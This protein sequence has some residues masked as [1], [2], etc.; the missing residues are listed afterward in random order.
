[1]S[2]RRAQ[3]WTLPL[4]LIVALALVADVLAVSTSRGQDDLPPG[5][6]AFVRK[7]D[8][9]VWKNG[10]STRIIEDGNA[11][12]PRWSPS[13]RFVLFVRSGDSYSDLILYDLEQSTEQQVTF[14]QPDMQP[15]SPDYV[16]NTSWVIDPD[17]TPNGLIAFASDATSDN[18]V[19][20]WLLSSPDLAPEPAPAAQP[21]D[22]IEGVSLDAAGSIAAYTVRVRE[23]NGLSHSAVAIRNLSDGTTKELVDDPNGAFDPAVSP[24]GSKIA[25]AIRDNN[26]NS[27]IWLS[28][29]SG[30]LTRVTEGAQATQPSWSPDGT[31]LAYMR[32]VNYKFELWAV[33][34]QDTGFGEPRRLFR[35][36]NL[37]PTSRISWTFS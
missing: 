19:I 37:D 23:D 12:D 17:W 26:E 29:L 28:D 20:L 10:E 21:E 33:P 34:R 15:G 22:D 18:S 7:G 6:I 14:N 35:F 13:G 8:I 9:W 31:W 24:D 2:I 11:S 1:M 3:V 5:R 30:T 36:A 27:D 25:L 16:A 32:M 4:T